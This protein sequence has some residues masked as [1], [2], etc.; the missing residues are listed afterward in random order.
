[1]LRMMGRGEQGGK[2][3]GDS[4]KKVR[5]RSWRAWG[6]NLEGGGKKGAAQRLQ[7]GGSSIMTRSGSWL[8]W[9]GRWWLG[10]DSQGTGGIVS[11]KI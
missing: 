10:T 2:G 1:M 7:K 6:G 8:S 4:G 5:S 3:P 9:N 11:A